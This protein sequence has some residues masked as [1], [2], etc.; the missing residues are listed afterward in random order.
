MPN[1]SGVILDDVEDMFISEAGRAQQAVASAGK[2]ALT[3]TYDRQ[4]SEA[5]SRKKK[6]C[7]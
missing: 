3:Q 6:P 1:S 7:E 5:T 4:L 2:L